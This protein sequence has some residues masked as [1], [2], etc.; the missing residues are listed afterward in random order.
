[1][2]AKTLIKT[3]D[4][5]PKN[6]SQIKKFQKVLG[7]LALTGGFRDFEKKGKKQMSESSEIRE[8]AR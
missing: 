1:M 8:G 5:Q 6:S 7:E 4:I 2:Y 3:V